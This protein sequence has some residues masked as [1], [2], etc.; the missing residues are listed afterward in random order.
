MAF[1]S[2]VKEPPKMIFPFDDFV[3][4]S[5]G[6]LKPAKGKFVQPS[7]PTQAIPFVEFPPLKLPPT[8]TAFDFWSQYNELTSSF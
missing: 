6:P 3:I 4:A 2:P 1:P 7:V 5:T 8:N